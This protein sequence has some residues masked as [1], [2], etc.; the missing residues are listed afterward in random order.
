MRVAVRQ[1]QIFPHPRR[2]HLCEHAKGGV[3]AIHQEVMAKMAEMVG[4]IAHIAAIACLADAVGLGICGRQRVQT[5]IEALGHLP[6]LVQDKGWIDHL[7]FG[8]GRDFHH[9]TSR[10][11]FPIA[12]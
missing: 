7:Q 9:T 2:H 11:I 10:M 1:L 8:C 6:V 3:L 4:Q 12:V 5:V